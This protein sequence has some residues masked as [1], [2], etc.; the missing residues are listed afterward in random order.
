[1]KN[2]ILKTITIIM[3]IM[4]FFCVCCLDSR[5]ALPFYIGAGVSSIWLL[6]FLYA[7]RDILC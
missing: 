5:N 1:M 7:N 4:F 2:F 6:L 3:A